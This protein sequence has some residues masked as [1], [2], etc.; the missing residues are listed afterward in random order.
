VAIH[1]AC[2]FELKNM[3]CWQW[4]EKKTKLLLTLVLRL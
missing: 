4:N 2:V 3:R 1:T